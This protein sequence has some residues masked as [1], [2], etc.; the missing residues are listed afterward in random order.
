MATAFA[1]L[2]RL[3][4]NGEL[5][6]PSQT[7]YNLQNAYGVSVSTVTGGFSRTA[8]DHMG[9]P[10]IIQAQYTLRTAEALQFFQDF[11]Y[12]T[13]L[14]GVL[15][16]RASLPTN[17][18]QLEEVACKIVGPVSFP[19]FTGFN[20]VVQLNLEALPIIDF[21][22]ARQRADLRSVYGTDLNLLVDD[23]ARL[24]TVQSTNSIGRVT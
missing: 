24:A 12:G 21:E 9:G 3:F 4:Y 10:S 22:L 8:S 11:Y 5:L 6:V 2:P 13:L 19:E 14:E 23:I 16:F 20:A 15:T 7:G 17:N 18:A 1:D